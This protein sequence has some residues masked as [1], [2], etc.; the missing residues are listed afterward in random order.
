MANEILNNAK[1]RLRIFENAIVY[2][3][4]LPK[5][6]TLEEY[7]RAHRSEDK[8]SM[9]MEFPNSNDEPI[10]IMSYENLKNYFLSKSEIN[11]KDFNIDITEK[12]RD[13]ANK[14][15]GNMHFTNA[16][17]IGTSMYVPDNRHKKSLVDSIKNFF[18][19]KKEE[20]KERKITNKFDV[21]KFFSDVKLSAEEEATKYRDRLAEYVN[22][23]GI[24]EKSGQIALKE[25]L[26]NNLVI[27]KYETILF[28]KG[29]VKAVTEET[30]VKL[31]KDSPKALAL[32]YIQNYIR[33]IPISVIKK[34]FEIDQLEIFDNYV[35]LHYDP[36]GVSYAKT[37]KEKEEEEKKKRDPIM[38][39]VIEGS[40]KLYYID[41][42]E[43]E[44]CDLTW[45]KMV[46]II[47]KQTI[48]KDFISE[49]IK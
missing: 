15:K 37:N 8:M 6:K 29:L 23:I 27:N 48:E 43:D 16:L 44:Y 2:D 9:N 31:A 11:I 36:N 24:A 47:G 18:N 20:N 41:S 34:K 13:I 30:I 35:I 12:M 40:T 10:E 7:K 19:K 46:D 14:T 17:S 3:K 26:F 25:K 42:W 45:D 22:C 33:N 4:E 38:F 5:F 21:V 28:S 32:D 1:N 49:T 39:G